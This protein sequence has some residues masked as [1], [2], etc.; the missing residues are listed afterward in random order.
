MNQKA[1][2]GIIF[3]IGVKQHRQDAGATSEN[4]FTLAFASRAGIIFCGM[5]VAAMQRIFHSSF[6]FA[7]GYN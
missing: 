3:T 2:D 5:A 1:C 4:L 7:G 6:C